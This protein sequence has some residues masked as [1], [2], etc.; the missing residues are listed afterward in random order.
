[1]SLDERLKHHH[2]QGIVDG[3]MRFS[4][5]AH[6]TSSVN[7]CE[8]V[9][10][11]HTGPMSDYAQRA[12]GIGAAVELKSQRWH[13]APSLIVCT[14]NNQI[15]QYFSV[16]LCL[17]TFG[18]RRLWQISCFS[19]GM[20][21]PLAPFVHQ[22]LRTV[23]VFGLSA[24]IIGTIAGLLYR[25]FANWFTKGIV[26]LVQRHRAAEIAVQDDLILDAPPCCPRCR[27]PMMKRVSKKGIKKDS[28]FRGC[29]G[30]PQCRGTRELV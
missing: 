5:A 6:F 22:F 9:I 17:T 12:G 13:D 11:I 16:G 1:M 7:R 23:L 26:E 20:A 25:S 15:C 28:R 3:Q 4:G 10:E 14:G 2:T 27:E 8:D 24:S 29:A 30:F 18:R 21:D 19:S